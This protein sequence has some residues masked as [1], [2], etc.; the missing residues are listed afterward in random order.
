MYMVHTNI[1]V[2]IY[3]CSAVHRK[4]VKRLPKYH[5]AN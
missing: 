5:I 3:V 2:S 1:Y 4:V